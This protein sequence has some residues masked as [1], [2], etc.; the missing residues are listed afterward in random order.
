VISWSTSDP[1]V[2]LASLVS[3]PALLSIS[4]KNGNHVVKMVLP[5]NSLTGR[6]MSYTFIL[7]IRSSFFIGVR[8]SQWTTFI[9]VNCWFLLAMETEL[10]TTFS[11]SA[12]QWFD[13]DLPLS[14]QFGYF[15]TNGRP[16][17]MEILRIRSE[18]SFDYRILPARKSFESPTEMWFVSV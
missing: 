7:L 3:N 1:S 5:A 18:S 2:N 13:V 10:E 11:F 14:Y 12:N 6:S 8:E 4:L 16:N 9:R 15:K 17:E